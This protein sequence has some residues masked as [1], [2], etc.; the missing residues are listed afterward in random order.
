MPHPT[1]ALLL[2]NQFRRLYDKKIKETTKRYGLTP[3]EVDVLLFL[4][5]N[6]GYD[7][8]KDISELRLLSKSC[9]SR[10]VDSL[11]RQGFLTSHE[12]GKDRRILHLSILPAAAGVVKDA[13]DSQQ[14][15]LSCAFLNFTEEERQ[16]LDRLTEK[17]TQNIKEALEEC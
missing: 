9:V 6:P 5:D 11:I 7:T 14:E 16:A 10:A 2:G 3:A 1:E 17:L 12:D 8:A 15:F 13:Q 4:A